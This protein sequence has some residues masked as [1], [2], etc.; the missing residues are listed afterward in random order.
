MPQSRRKDGCC[1]CRRTPSLSHPQAYPF[2]PCL[3]AYPF[4]PHLQAWEDLNFKIQQQQR[5][6]NVALYYEVSCSWSR[7]RFSL[8]SKSLAHLARAQQN[9]PALLSKTCLYKRAC[10]LAEVSV[11]L[12]PTQHQLLY[13]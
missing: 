5:K 2:S 1:A 7:F 6:I 4:F 12:P 9:M 8:S 10:S 3:Q 13:V 11:S